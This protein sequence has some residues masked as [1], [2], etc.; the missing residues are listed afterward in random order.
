MGIGRLIQKHNL[1]T[2]SNIPIPYFHP[3]LTPTLPPLASMAG[4][5]AVFWPAN[6]FT[7]AKLPADLQAQLVAFCVLWEDTAKVAM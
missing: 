7:L 3:T 2:R 1:Q 5:C 6:M 4:D